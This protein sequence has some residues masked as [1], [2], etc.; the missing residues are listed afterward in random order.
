MDKS[1]NG[2]HKPAHVI[3]VGNEKGGSGKSTIAVHVAVALVKAGYRVATVDLDSHNKTLTHFIEDRRNWATRSG[4]ALE[5][6][7][8]FRVPEA[9]SVR[10]DDNENADRDA[11]IKAVAAIEHACDFLVI[12]TPSADGYLTWLAL[13]IADTLIT[14]LNDSFVDFDALGD[15]DPVTYTLNEP[16][17]YAKMVSEERRARRKFDH[18]DID[19]IVMRNR[20]TIVHSRNSERL[21]QA[22]KDLGL[23]MGF[24]CARGF[25][26]R[27]IYRDLFPRGLT[28]LD[29]VD[30]PS[31][32]KRHVQ[33]H[34]HAR[35]EVEALIATLKLPV[36][37]KTRRHAAA[38]AEWFVA[39]DSQLKFDEF[40][41]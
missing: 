37:E 32:G 21:A 9:A 41:Q 34:R 3:V 35:E 4:A 23:Q 17:I 31:L 19:W 40:V 30:E 39:R 38:R 12:D 22:L 24:R 8:H 14:P 10:R 25:T 7:D 6:P 18:S 28:V 20:L 27:A 33:S 1:G 11:L 15:V 36:D 13:G 26:E 2:N 29:D 5:T 16:S